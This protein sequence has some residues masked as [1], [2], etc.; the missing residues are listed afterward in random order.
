MANGTLKVSNIETSS[1]SG[2]I[3]VGASGETVDFSNATTTLN[4][5][6]K[7]T[8]AFQAY[9]SGD[10]AISNGSVTKVTFNT[11]DFDTDNC[12]D[13]STNYRFTP[14]V[15]GKYYI[16]VTV[17]NDTTAGNHLQTQARLNKNGSNIMNRIIDMAGNPGEAATVKADIIVDMNGSSD[18]V[19]AYAYS[20]LNDSGNGNLQSSSFR[21]AFLGY[22]VIGA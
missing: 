20:S 4:S 5:A 3:T 9:L 2:T 11:E 16:S 7:S 13:N 12:Y 1:G 8:P 6:M 10:Q 18:Y 15:A 22:R 14:N 19:E 21:S 17:T